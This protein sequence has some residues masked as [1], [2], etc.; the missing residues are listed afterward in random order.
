MQRI[1][2]HIMSITK[3][4]RVALLISGLHFAEKYYHMHTKSTV[5][6]NYE[7]CLQN[8]QRYVLGFL[9]AQNISY[10]TFISTNFTQKLTSFTE[11]FKPRDTFVNY[12]SLTL[13]NIQ[14]RNFT[15]LNGIALILS[16][17]IKD[18]DAILIIRPDIFIRQ[19]METWSI[20]WSKLNFN[21]LL[22]QPTFYDDNFYIVPSHL[23][24]KFYNVLTKCQDKM[25]HYIHS[26]LSLA[27]TNDQINF[28]KPQSGVLVKELNNYSIVR[29]FYGPDKPCIAV[30]KGFVIYEPETIDLLARSRFTVLLSDKGKIQFST[31]SDCSYITF[32]RSLSSKTTLYQWF[33][34]HVSNKATNKIENDIPTIDSNEFQTKTMYK[35]SAEYMIYEPHISRSKKR[36]IGFKTHEPTRFW[37]ID[38]DA[39]NQGIWSKI[40]GYFEVSKPD[41]FIFICDEAPPAFQITIKNFTLQIIDQTV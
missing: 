20:D 10:D 18:Y 13:P 21:T 35:F 37:E 19:G 6:V 22:E 31:V 5:S 29:Y 9:E 15:L 30:L 36:K 26:E 4:R 2:T 25:F 38:M 3:P 34:F 7:H 8:I 27:I 12:I 40:E 33:G 16:K 24:L 17:Y 41:I 32:T 11:I 1:K 23:L 39:I 28:M 14:S